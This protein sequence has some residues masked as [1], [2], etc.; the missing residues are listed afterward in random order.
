MPYNNYEPS[1][2]KETEITQNASCIGVKKQ[3]NLVVDTISFRFNRV[4]DAQNI[5][6]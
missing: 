1:R 6:K 2:F 5:V 3:I 4:A